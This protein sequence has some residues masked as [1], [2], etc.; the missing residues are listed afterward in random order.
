MSSARLRAALLAFCVSVLGC[1]PVHPPAGMVSPSTATPPVPRGPGVRLQADL[2]YGPDAR[3][4][5]DVYRP[6]RPSGPILVMVHGGGWRHGHKAMPVVVEGK[7][8][9]WVAEQGWI[10]VSAG[11]RLAPRA[12]PREQAQDVARAL[13]W[14]QQMAP[15]W[16]GDADAIVLM[17]HSAGG[18]LVALASAS[19][20]VRHAGGAQRWLASVVLDGAA[21]DPVALMQDK[22]LPLYDQAFGTH[23]GDWREASPTDALSASSPPIP[24]LLVC[25]VPRPDDACGQSRRFA[26]RVHAVGGRAEVFPV[27]LTH[28]AV[29]AEVGR[30]LR[31]TR[32]IEDFLH[33][34]TAT[35]KPTSPAGGGQ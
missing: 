35:R 1:V 25:S 19:E 28:R 29:N 2:A 31:Y 6:D 27:P 3:Q 10:L 13:A 16:G 17:G 9:H 30:D 20:A 33:S 21:F 22:H 26:Q 8:Q 5:V 7:V 34:V 23:P 32:V 14:V 15:A 4:R 18:H 24:L 11:Y 12:R